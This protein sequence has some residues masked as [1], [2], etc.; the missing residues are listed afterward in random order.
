MKLKQVGKSGLK[1]S[2][3]GL[4][5]LTWG[6]DTDEYECDQQLNTFIEHGGNLI[7]TAPNY[8]NSEYILGK[9]LEEKYS[10]S[11]LIL[12]SKSGIKFTSN[13][14]HIDISK[15]NLLENLDSTLKTLNT[16]Y[17]DIW[18]VAQPDYSIDFYELTDTLEYALSTGRTRYVGL[19][20]FSA[21]SATQ[22]HTL[23][24]S[25]NQKHSVSA[26]E[27]EY[28]LLERGIEK[29]VIPACEYN[30]IGI[31]AWSPLGRGIL[32]GKYREGIPTDSRGA[33]T[34]LYGFVEPYLNE[35]NAHIVEGLVTAADGLNLAPSQVAL[36]WIINKPFISSAL[37]GAR[38]NSQLQELLNDVENT[39]PIQI[40]NALDTI[41]NI[42]IG[43]P[44][45]F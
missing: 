27:M 45:K 23:L 44:E 34:H 41:S 22:I 11:D 37:V 10:R 42:K 13:G 8:G 43:Y 19:S 39:L 1:V 6:R 25:S 29:E 26:L 20:N 30:N 35:R 40:E 18:F 14:S 38:N 28:S 21:W 16:D 7:D 5:T 12:S 33:T 2:A 9:L 4:G 32:T 15:K 36:K 31:F 17:L 24:N 3:V